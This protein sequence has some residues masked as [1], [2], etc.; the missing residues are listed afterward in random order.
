MQYLVMNNRKNQCFHALNDGV[1]FE[2]HG[3]GNLG[4]TIKI[5][6]SDLDTTAK[7]GKRTACC[8]WCTTL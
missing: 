8:A 2:D 7:R 4:I 6:S 5:L 3:D 1:G